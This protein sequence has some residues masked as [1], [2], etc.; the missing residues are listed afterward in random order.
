MW[1]RV[2]MVPGISCQGQ[3]YSYAS[4]ILGSI[5]PSDPD[6]KTFPED[7]FIE[8]EPTLGTLR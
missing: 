1:C 8:I 7:E 2:G 6:K 4:F 5:R 3:E